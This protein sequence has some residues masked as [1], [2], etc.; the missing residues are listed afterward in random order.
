MARPRGPEVVKKWFAYVG[1]ESPMKKAASLWSASQAHNNFEF[2]DNATK[3][4]FSR[5]QENDILMI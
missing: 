1:N 4:M 2:L 5:V 3:P